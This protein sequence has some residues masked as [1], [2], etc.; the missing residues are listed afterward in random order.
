MA[1]QLAFGS[2]GLV[3]CAFSRPAQAQ[4]T[5]SVPAD[6][7][8]AT[9]PESNPPP[10][11]TPAPHPTEAEPVH[12]PRHWYGSEILISDAASV[13]VVALGFALGPARG[14]GVVGLGVIGYALV[15][16]VI[17]LTHGRWGMAPASL[18]LRVFTPALGLLVG[19]AAGHCPAVQGDE[20]TGDG[21]VLCDRNS[22]ALGALGAALLVTAIDSLLFSRERRP[23]DFSQSQYSAR[24]GFAPLFSAAGKHAEIRAYASF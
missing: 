21:L 6:L 1:R 7:P 5:L 11:V 23:T 9:A 2:L 12:P 24:I 13:S 10:T 8:P 14:N 15:P 18:A 20:D 16:P 4:T 17:H 3:L 19:N 22:A